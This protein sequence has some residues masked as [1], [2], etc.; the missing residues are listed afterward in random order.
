MSSI[1][2]KRSYAFLIPLGTFLVLSTIVAGW[3]WY[4]WRTQPGDPTDLEQVAFGGRVYGRICAS[5]HGSDLA[6][7]LGWRQPLKDGSRLAPAH[8]T[9]G[10][11]W[12]HADAT[13]F[14]VV[15]FGGDYLRPD[16]GVSRMPA[17]DE[18]ITDEEVWAVIAFIKS[19]WPATLQEAQR[20]A[21][22]DARPAGTVEPA[23]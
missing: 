14:K 9:E 16:G 8:N 23:R 10:K 4:Q 18:K 17:F 20:A 7:Q 13:L 21:M 5:C 1:G 11:T 22:P 3:F 15:K 2:V 12:H 19:N 6:G